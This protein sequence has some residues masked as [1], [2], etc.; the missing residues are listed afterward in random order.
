[1]KD[2]ITYIAISATLYSESGSCG[3]KK[4]SAYDI[5]KQKENEV[6]SALLKIENEKNKILKEKARMESER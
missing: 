2:I 4:R 5:K 3:K 6:T 1:M